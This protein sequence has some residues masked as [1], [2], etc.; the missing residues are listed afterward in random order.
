MK[1]KDLFKKLKNESID[2]IPNIKEKV[3]SNIGI[4]PNEKVKQPFFKYRYKLGLSF[5]LLFL[6]LLISIVS[7]TPKAYSKSYVLIDINPS[8]ELILDDEDNIEEINPLNPD[9]L[10]LLNDMN[11][12]LKGKTVQNAI[13]EVVNASTV[14]GYLDKNDEESVVR[15][16]S[17]N[18]NKEKENKL[19]QKIEVNIKNA[20]SNNNIHSN[21]KTSDPLLEKTAKEN[22]ITLGQ[23][24][25]I[26]KAL[27]LDKSLDLKKA[28]KMDIENIAKIANDKSREKL[29][30]FEDSY[31]SSLAPL[32]DSKNEAISKLEDFYSNIFETLDDIEEMIDN[33]KP[34][35]TIKKDLQKLFKQIPNFEGE[36]NVK[37]YSE[38]QTLVNRIKDSLNSD[39]DFYKD[40]INDKYNLQKDAYRIKVKD[41]LKQND[42]YKFDFEFDKDFEV[43]DNYKK[44][45]NKEEQQITMLIQR[46]STLININMNNPMISKKVLENIE[47]YHEEYLDLMDNDEIR[48]EFKNSDF[49][50]NFN[51]KFQEFKENLKNFNIYW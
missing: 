1:N 33:R 24:V 16:I 20:F 39:L 30:E 35:H 47:E 37:T 25:L 26:N 15:V 29:K 3:F 41:D 23:M 13:M 19:K 14:N 50:I 12:N 28:L 48:N 17:V 31:D 32:E 2:F 21:L 51:N 9:A 22:K 44:Q 34:L 8:F 27:E 4:S 6:I 42:S 5:V 7:F 49:I 10:L 18:K 40:I 38:A 43:K 46:I 11:I 45:N 36:A